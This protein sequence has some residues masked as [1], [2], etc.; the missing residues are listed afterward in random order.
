MRGSNPSLR[1]AYDSI[2]YPSA[3]IVILQ[4]VH[5]C[6]LEYTKVCLYASYFTHKC[7]LYGY[8]SGSVLKYV[9]KQG[10]FRLLLG[11]CIICYDP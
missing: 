6:Q 7:I 5:I 4:G 8:F 10:K 3:N 11:L 2:W 9:Y 1:C